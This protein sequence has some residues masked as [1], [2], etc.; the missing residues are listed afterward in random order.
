MSAHF[1]AHIQAA[2]GSAGS[3]VLA[4]QLLTGLIAPANGTFGGSEAPPT[5]R[6]VTLEEFQPRSWEAGPGPSSLGWVLPQEGPGGHQANSHYPELAGQERA[7]PT[8]KP[9]AFLT[10]CPEAQDQPDTDIH[11]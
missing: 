10:S 8:P 6:M 4:G 2:E 5:P 9:T 7:L 3:R 1:S 11:L